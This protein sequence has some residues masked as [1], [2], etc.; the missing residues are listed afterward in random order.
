MMSGP[1]LNYSEQTAE[2][3][4]HVDG[5]ALSGRQESGTE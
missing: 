5:D 2:V 3:T 4:A 1:G